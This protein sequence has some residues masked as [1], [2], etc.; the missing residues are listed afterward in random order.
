MLY[1]LTRFVGTIAIY[2][3]YFPKFIGRKNTKIKG[4]GIVISNHTSFWDPLIISV[5][6]RRQIYWMSKA[7]LLKSKFA[8]AFFLGVKAFSVE[9]GTSDFAAIKHTFK[10]LKK[11]KLLG[12][13]PEGTRQK[14]GKMIKFESGT[15]FIA[16]KNNA[17]VIPIY[18]R[19]DYKFFKRKKVIIGEP[20]LLSDHVGSKTDSTTVRKATDFL[21][22]ILKDMKD[23]K[24]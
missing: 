13:F 2:F 5:V 15:A 9:R 3:A 10:V 23:S 18:F 12:I 16:L 1:Y 19:G 24:V 17:P 22:K 21:E 4:K 11:G 20:I 14:D 7:E 6:F 8:K